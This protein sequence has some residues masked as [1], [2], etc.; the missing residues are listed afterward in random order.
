MTRLIPL[1]GDVLASILTRTV[2]RLWRPMSSVGPGSLGLWDVSLQRARV[3][4]VFFNPSKKK[5]S[6]IAHRQ[7]NYCPLRVQPVLSLIP[8]NRPRTV[9]HGVRYLEATITWRCEKWNFEQTAGAWNF[10]LKVTTSMRENWHGKTSLRQ[11]K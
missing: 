8:H 10:I 7:H 2:L 9:N 4:R 11:H 6:E 1:N 3:G 5:G